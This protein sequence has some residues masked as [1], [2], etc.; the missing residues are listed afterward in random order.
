MKVIYKT[1]FNILGTFFLGLGV[2]G[3]I[4]PLLPATPFLLLASACYIRGSEKLYNKLMNNK[5]LGPFIKNFQQHRAIPLRVKWILII[6]LWFSISYSLIQ[7]DQLII[8]IPFLVIAI[9]ITALIYK[10]KTLKVEY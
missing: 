7:F 8:R 6:M 10:I 2:L 1:I 9:L 4:L 3:I 5:V